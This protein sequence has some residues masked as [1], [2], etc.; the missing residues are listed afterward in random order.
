[1]TTNDE[2]IKRYAVIEHEEEMRLSLTYNEYDKTLNEARADERQ[3]IIKI[4]NDLWD[5]EGNKIDNGVYAYPFEALREMIIREI[6]RS[7]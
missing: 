5:R 6:N 7:D 1:M 2:I 4:L 3:H